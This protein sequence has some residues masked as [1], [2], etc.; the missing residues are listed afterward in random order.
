MDISLRGTPLIRAGAAPDIDQIARGGAI[1]KSFY[2][3]PVCSPTRSALMTGRYPSSTGVDSVVRPHAP[4]GLKLE[5]QT[6]P[7]VLQSAGYETA[8]SGKWHL[9][10]FEPAYR[11]MQRGFDH[12]LFQRQWRANA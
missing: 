10:E 1:L 12:H 8:I 2:V 3:Q 7:Q 5:E 11:P 9:G 6:L 4:W